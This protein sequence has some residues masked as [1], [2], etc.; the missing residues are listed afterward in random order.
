MQLL[1]DLSLSLSFSLTH[2]S[3]ILHRRTE[4]IPVCGEKKPVFFFLINILAPFFSCDLIDHLTHLSIFTHTYEWGFIIL[5][6]IKCI[7]LHPKKEIGTVLGQVN[8]RN[9]RENNFV[10]MNDKCIVQLQR[11]SEFNG[12]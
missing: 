1:L 3:R 5:P 10:S 8:G 4:G 2:S 6:V 12:K 9:I 7:I 11:N